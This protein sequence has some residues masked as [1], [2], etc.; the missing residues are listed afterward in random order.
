[1]SV[2]SKEDFLKLLETEAIYQSKLQQQRLLPKQLDVL[3]QL[4]GSFPWQI[5]SVGSLVSAIAV[6]FIK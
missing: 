5:I 4:V 3:A 6:Q 1:M 2:K